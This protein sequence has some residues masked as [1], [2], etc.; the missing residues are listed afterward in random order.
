MVAFPHGKP[1][2]RLPELR[3][4]PGRPAD[5]GRGAVRVLQVE[6]SSRLV[7]RRSH[8]ELRVTR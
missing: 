8:D 5:R 2:S 3:R 7:G 4:S 1:Q 6:V